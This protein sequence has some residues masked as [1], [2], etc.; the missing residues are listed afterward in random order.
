MDPEAPARGWGQGGASVGSTR[1]QELLFKKY[2][3]FWEKKR[4]K[5]LYKNFF[6]YKILKK[7]QGKTVLG[8]CSDTQSVCV[9]VCVSRRV[10]EGAFR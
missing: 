3:V 4:K 7:V 5:N 8:A 9:C 1:H 6:T 2:K 10:S